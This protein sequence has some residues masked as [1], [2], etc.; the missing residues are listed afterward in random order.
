MAVYVQHGK[1]RKKFKTARGARW[2]QKRF[3]GRVVKG[4]KRKAGKKRRR[5]SPRRR[6]T[7]KRRRR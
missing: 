1:R 7:A 2:H 5:S 3:G 4:K 6:K